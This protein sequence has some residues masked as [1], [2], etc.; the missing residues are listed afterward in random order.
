MSRILPPLPEEMS[1]EQRAM[2]D[3]IVNGPRSQ[4]RRSPFIDDEGRLQ[5]PFGMW[6]V[7]PN[8]GDAVQNVGVAVRYNTS[9]NDRLREIGIL[10]VGAAFQANYEWYAHA[11]LAVKAGV[12]EA[13]LAT[14]KAGDMPDGLGEDEQ[15]AV[16]LARELVFDRT[17]SEATM[18]AV[19]ACLGEPATV[20]LVVLIGYY[21]LLCMTLNA[22]DV[23][24]P[25]GA[26]KPFG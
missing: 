11:P 9:L 7:A 8:V 23:E 17:A 2:Y 5:G 22:F 24:V 4:G 3:D 18:T 25:A 1:A 10:A 20:E 26:E 13:Q 6:N 12:A 15:L 16:Q 14:L 21:S 19:I